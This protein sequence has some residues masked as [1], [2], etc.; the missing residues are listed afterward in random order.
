M[1]CS[2]K[3]RPAEKT[4]SPCRSL[5]ASRTCEVRDPVKTKAIYAFT[6]TVRPTV[7][8]GE[9]PRQRRDRWLRA[10]TACAGSC[11][12]AACVAPESGGFGPALIQDHEELLEANQAGRYDFSG[13]LIRSGSKSCLVSS[14]I[15]IKRPAREVSPQCIAHQSIDVLQDQNALDTAS[16]SLTPGVS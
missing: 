13:R 1:A 14:H 4:P 6:E 8:T 5:R 9:S 11:M 12:P 7:C 10:M 3:P 16:L 2:S 15:A